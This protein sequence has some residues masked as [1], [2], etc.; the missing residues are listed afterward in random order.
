MNVS[1]LCSKINVELYPKQLEI[2]NRFYD[3]HYRKLVAVL[4]RRSGKDLLCLTMALHEAEYLIQL[5]NPL[6]YYQLHGISPIHILLVSHSADQARIL[7]TELKEKII[8]SNYFSDKIGHVDSDKI[9]LLTKQDK[10]KEKTTKGSVVIMSAHHNSKSLLGKRIFALIFNEAM[11]ENFKNTWNALVPSTAEFN[12]NDK[13][14]SK[15]ITISSAR[16]KDDFLHQLFILSDPSSLTVQYPTWDV[17]PSR[18]REALRD[19]FKFMSDEEFDME[20]GGKF[21][22]NENK[23]VSLRLHQ[24]TINTLQS[25][26]RKMAFQQDKELSYTDTIR[27]AINQY[28]D[29]KG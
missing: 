4:G 10:Q 24:S 7:F 18:S 20:F 17:V 27:L 15:I 12:K 19:E 6:K 29:G 9:W 23:T 5:S 26:A 25:I 14:E 21:S 11:H 8:S 22:S 13:L 28:I 1:E 3:N 2:L 16:S